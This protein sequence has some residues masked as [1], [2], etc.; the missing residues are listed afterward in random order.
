MYGECRQGKVLE[1]HEMSFKKKKE[2]EKM[3]LKSLITAIA[4]LSMS[5]TIMGVASVPSN[6]EEMDPPSK[7]VSV[8]YSPELDIYTAVAAKSSDSGN[9]LI[10]YSSGDGKNWVRSNAEIDDSNSRIGIIVANGHYVNP[11]MIVW[12]DKEDMFVMGDMAN[13]YTSRDGITWER[14]GTPKKYGNMDGSGLSS[15]IELYNMYFDGTNY[16]ATTRINNEVARTIDGDLLRWYSTTLDISNGKPLSAITGTDSGRIYV[17]SGMA[18]QGAYITRD[19]ELTWELAIGGNV[20][21]YKTLGSIYS[22]YLDRL[23]LVGVNGNRNTLDSNSTTAIN[24]I[25]PATNTSPEG[26]KLTLTNLGTDRDTPGPAGDVMISEDGSEFVIVFMDGNIYAVDT[27]VSDEETEETPI[28][29]ARQT[30]NYLKVKPRSEADDIGT[31]PLTGIARGKSGYVAIGGTPG[32]SSL[33]SS[34][35]ASGGAVFIPKDISQ[36]YEKAVFYTSDTEP[37][38]TT[39]YI[40]GDTD[41]IMIENSVKTAQFGVIVRDQS[42]A[43][44]EG[45]GKEFSWSV[46]DEP[47]GVSV[48]EDGVLSVTAEAQPGYVTVVA[49]EVGG[50]LTADKN[51]LLTSQPFPASIKVDGTDVKLIKTKSTDREYSFTATVNDALGRPMDGEEVTWRIDDIEGDGISVDDNGI[52]T[53]SPEAQNGTFKLTAISKT[54]PHIEGSIELTVTS[55]GGV[56]IKGPAELGS[57]DTID[58][59]KLLTDG[60]DADGNGED[61]TYTYTSFIVDADGSMIAGESCTYSIKGRTNYSRSGV[62]LINDASGNAVIKV[63]ADAVTQKLTLVAT[64]NNN[65]DIID[66]YELNIVNSLVKNSS[67]RAGIG[68]DVGWTTISGQVAAGTSGGMTLMRMNASDGEEAIAMSDPFPIEAGQTYDFGFRSKVSDGMNNNSSM[69]AMILFCDSNGAPIDFADVYDTNIENKKN[70]ESGGTSI[71]GHQTAMEYYNSATAP[72]GTVTAYIMLGVTGPIKNADFYDI[73]VYSE[74]DMI[75]LPEL[76]NYTCEISGFDSDSITVRVEIPDNADEEDVMY[77]AVYDEQDI[78][79][80]AY[81]ADSI[82]PENIFDVPEGGTKVKAFIWDKDMT[83]LASARKDL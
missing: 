9:N 83:S 22:P 4:V 50:T 45:A 25:D 64:V 66:E 61:R 6:A 76:E 23:I 67:F 77:V 15:N 41:E 17:S 19:G 33:I 65:D 3:K 18:D 24:F 20:G 34:S 8:C 35:P 55:I 44:M 58:I 54:D 28:M 40:S 30:S 29:R 81:I 60:L 82:M 52:V 73:G 43:P 57:V 2:R 37:E 71:N 47:A 62:T 36:G 68:E 39:A 74:A 80:K 1:K 38:A 79:I 26:S 49:E 63:S 59:K 13:V 7:L 56:T 48:S 75:E 10:M 46:K 21:P 78:L 42:G 51:I 11:N 14:L 12:N 16:W 53:V 27:K 70:P 31:M 72:E 5:A 32:H 69:Y